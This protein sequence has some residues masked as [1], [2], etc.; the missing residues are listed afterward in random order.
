MHRSSLLKDSLKSELPE[1]MDDYLEGGKAICLRFNRHGNILAAGT[2]EGEVVLWDFDTRSIAMKLDGRSGSINSITFP[3]PMT[4]ERLISG[5]AGGCIRFWNV[6]EGTSSVL[7]LDSEVVR[8]ESSRIRADEVLVTAASGPPKLLIWEETEGDDSP[9]KVSRAIALENEEDEAI[10]PKKK[11]DYVTVFSQL[12]ARVLSC[13]AHGLL[14]EFTLQRG[15]DG[16]ALAI[17][18]TRKVDLPNRTVVKEIVFAQDGSRFLVNSADRQIRVFD[19]EDLCVLACFNDVVNRSQWRCA[20]FSGQGDHILGGSTGAEHKLH[21]WRLVDGQLDKT[22]DGPK[23]G[24]GGLLWHPKRPVAVSLGVSYGGIYIWMKSQAQNWA[25][26][27]PNFKEIDENK[28]YDEKEDEFD[29]P[30]A[31]IEKK[32]MEEK[33]KRE[34]LIEVDVT[35]IERV[36]GE[37]E[38][39]VFYLPAIPEPPSAPIVPLGYIQPLVKIPKPS[40]KHNSTKKKR[41]TSDGRELGDVKAQLREGS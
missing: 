19:A 21:I 12:G 11:Q 3:S 18:K 27:A 34:A 14:R 9:A 32:R 2:E 4:G 23:E 36:E 24:I 25:A 33:L 5:S 6:V 16:R 29:I 38:V 26:F 30:D 10:D 13:R 20:I 22:L 31:S 15:E 7:K 28:D 37:D 40:K 35:T 17:D 1:R 41:R 8:L 39:P